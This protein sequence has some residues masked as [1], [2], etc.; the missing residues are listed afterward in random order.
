VRRREFITLLGGATVWP[1]QARAQQSAMP[2]IGFLHTDSADLSVDRL[3]GF[4]Q[5]LSET[6][7]AEGR[8]V[9]I[10]YRWAENDNDRFPALAADLARRQVAVI[11]A[12]SPAAPAAKAA[13][14][15]IPIV[16][17][18]GIDPVAIGLVA[19]LNRP[20]GNLTGVSQL[21][22]QLGPKRLGLLHEAIPTATSIALLDNP[23]NSTA[24]VQSRDLRA[25]ARTLG[26]ELH[27]LHASTERDFDAA[28]TTLIQLRARGLLIGVDSFFT[29]RSEQLATLTLRYAVPALYEFRQF[30]AAGGLMSYGPSLSDSYRLA[31]IYAGRILKGEKPA[32]LP[33]VQST[34]FELVINLKTAKALGITMPPSL[35]ATADEVIE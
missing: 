5:G 16:F 27:V 2:V 20:G 29:S 18:S 21:N 28:L 9:V 17:V 3:R 15:T 8:N 32:D 25:A 26:L 6:G 14:G 1:L 11:V 31:G 22:V 19:S 12:N 33:V 34:K 7:Y 13:T 23:T 30:A 4:R 10:E 35:L 24:E